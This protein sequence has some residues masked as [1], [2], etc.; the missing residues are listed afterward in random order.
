MAIF[1]I[2]ETGYNRKLFDDLVREMED[3]AR[4]LFGPDIQLDE[5]SFFGLFIR[6]Y[7]FF[8]AD[9]WQ[10]A[11]DTYNGAYVDTAAGV[12]LDAVVKY[13]DVSRN[14]SVASRGTVTF[15]GADL[16][17]IP[18]GT[19]VASG[20]IQFSTDVEDSIVSVSVDIAVT[21]VEL[22]TESNVPATTID[23]L[24]NP[25]SGIT[26]VSNAD[27]TTGGQDEETDSELRSRYFLT[28]QTGG[29]ATL[30]AIRS[31]ILQVTG[32]RTATIIENTTNVVDGD[33]R[34]PHSFESVVDGGDDIAVAQA[35]LDSKAAGI[36]TFGSVTE[37]VQDDSGTDRTINFSRPTGFDI[38]VNITVT[39]SGN[40]PVDGDDQVNEALVDFINGLLIG[41]DV[42]VTQLI[43]ESFTIAGVID[44]FVEISDDN[45]TFDT[46]N[47][48]IDSDEKAQTTTGKVVVT[49]V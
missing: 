18:A 49:S 12:Q 36:D 26:D 10:L 43:A 27:D 31:D 32:V 30:D 48:V 14:Q 25:I 33:G 8:Q 4:A 3:R 13:A 19:L 42:V 1:G 17:L 2:T 24:I 35:I 28:L 6:I 16:T 7:A 46:T 5:N 47:I 41:D 21:A 34:P 29:K 23:T 15:T 9:V 44:S 22:G 38:W 20:D 40:Y 39:T 11:E 37:V 45:I